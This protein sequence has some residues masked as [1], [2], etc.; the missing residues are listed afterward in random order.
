LTTTPRVLRV[1][2]WAMWQD[3]GNV[4][5]DEP[6][7]TFV[8]GNNLDA[9]GQPNGSGKSSLFN[10]MW[11]LNF[12]DHQLATKKRSLKQIARPDTSIAMS[13]DCDQQH[14]VARMLETAL[15][16]TVDGS[17][18]ESRVKGH[19]RD[20]LLGLMNTTQELWSS[21]VHVNGIASNP[22][23]RGTSAQRCQFLE[24][25][26]DLD[27]WAA[28]HAQI[29][30]KL[31]TF[32][33]AQTDLDLAK[34]DLSALPRGNL[35]NKEAE[36]EQASELATKYSSLMGEL[37]ERLAVAKSLPPKPARNEHY[38]ASKIKDLERAVASTSNYREKH[39]IWSESYDRK[40]ALM[41]ELREYPKSTEP[42]EDVEEL[43][44]KVRKSADRVELAVDVRAGL[45]QVRQWHKLARRI[46]SDHGIRY[47]DLAELHALCR[48]WIRNLRDGDT[49]CPVCGGK[50]QKRVSSADLRQLE[51]LVAELPS[52]D[53]GRFRED[54]DLQAVRSKH[55]SLVKRLELAR[56]SAAN[57]ANRSRIIDHLKNL[58]VVDKPTK[59]T[60]AEVDRHT[61]EKYRSLLADARSWRNREEENLEELQ[62]RRLAAETKFRSNLGTA[63]KL[64]REIGELRSVQRERKRLEHRVEELE[65]EV[66]LQPAYKS[67]HAAYSP[68]GMRLWL[69]SE[70]LEALVQ[71]LNNS[72]VGTRDRISFGYK[73]GRNRDLSLTA[74][75][76][77]GTF[78]VRMLS[79]AEGNLFCLNLLTVLLPML[80]SRRRSNMLILDELDSNCSTYVAH[81]IAREYL[82]RLAKTVG[83]LM[84][85]T[86]RTVAEF[87]TPKASQ[88]L[89]ERV[90][91]TSSI[92]RRA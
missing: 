8:R 4:R 6:G 76:I 3:S 64:E 57:A 56:T 74:S 62:A 2:N 83:T 72:N 41:E 31:A 40:M 63:S 49:S 70:L 9:G 44:E 43:K 51:K 27:R 20:R 25:A 80:P 47:G 36:L 18:V 54:V 12:N 24:R 34:S 88:L 82:P 78:D 23:V 79:G 86:P 22:L 30:D 55:A 38:Y 85:V 21:T 42:A 15:A 77:K 26:F 58:V 92:V 35:A 39:R 32:K 29:G 19:D 46:A 91:G 60:T 52:G 50:F 28:K 81:M 65:R 48:S 13:V 14:V 71:G 5:L 7:I 68:T 69:L 84:V 17:K 67:L 66:S 53:L 37:G 59:P 61:L 16:V 73:L 45:D 11:A 87:N 75:N 89:V 90:G 10:A 33:R 1:K